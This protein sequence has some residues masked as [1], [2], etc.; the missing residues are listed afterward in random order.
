MTNPKKQIEVGD[1]LNDGSVIWKVRSMLISDTSERKILLGVD[2]KKGQILGY[3]P[4]GFVLC[5]NM[6]FST[7]NGVVYAQKDGEQG[8]YVDAMSR[9]SA[10][11]SAADGASAYVGNDGAITYDRPTTSKC[12]VKCLGHVE[13]G[14]LIFEPDSLA[15]QIR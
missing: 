10:N 13:Q 6:D 15:I 2:C 4:G 9:G 8:Q 12:Y 7:I 14:L 11:V 5:D 3:K 1:L